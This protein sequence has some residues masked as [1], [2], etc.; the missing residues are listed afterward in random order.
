MFGMPRTAVG[1]VVGWIRDESN[2]DSFVELEIHILP[3]ISP[4]E[5]CDCILIDFNVDGV[6]VNKI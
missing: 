6:M 2:P 5:K 4:D 3:A 1:A